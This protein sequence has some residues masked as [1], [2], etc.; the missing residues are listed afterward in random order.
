MV[1]PLPSEEETRSSPENL[2]YLLRLR[3][4]HRSLFSYFFV[5]SSA[6]RSHFL[7]RFISSRALHRVTLRDEKETEK[8]FR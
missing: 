3:A 8:N 7:C 4:N 1:Q 2:S 6:H 5:V